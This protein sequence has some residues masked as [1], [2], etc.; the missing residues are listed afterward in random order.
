MVVA[1]MSPDDGTRARAGERRLSIAL[2][3]SLLVHAVTIGLLRGVLPAI[4]TYAQ[5]GVGNLP[6]LQAV[7]AGPKSEPAPEPAAPEPAIDASLLAPPATN[8]LETPTQRPPPATAPTFG[9]G[10]IRSGSSNPDI[11]IAVG[12]IDD[13]ARL[14]PDYLL[15]LAQRFP[16]RISKPPQLLGSPIVM[17]PPAAI[18]SGTERRVAALLI[19]DANGKIAESE[20]I[21]NDPVFGPVVL[22]A[23]KSAEFTPAEID[24]TPVSYW[25]IVEFVFMLERPSA[26]PPPKRTTRAATSFR[27]PN[28]GK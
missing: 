4:N 17:Y 10:P 13:P 24:T 8:P 27:Q 18:A 28:V 12:L 5:G 2:G 6:A 15:R 26:P 23:L 14:G 7:L 19:L 20:L 16:E 1:A 21:P 25:A 22:E 11:S 3:I 9:G